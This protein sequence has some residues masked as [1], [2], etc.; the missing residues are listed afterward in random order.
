MRKKSI[1]HNVHNG[2]NEKHS[3]QKRKQTGKSIYPSLVLV[4]PVVIVVVKNTSLL[5]RV[6]E[7]GNLVEFNVLQLA[8]DFFHYFHFGCNGVA[9]VYG[10]DEFDFLG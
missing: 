8:V 1:N 7:L 3:K 9:N 6:L 10:F 4:V 2:H 5:P